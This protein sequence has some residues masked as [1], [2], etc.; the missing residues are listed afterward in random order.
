[1]EIYFLC[2]GD[3]EIPLFKT[4]RADFERNLSEHG[5]AGIMNE[6]YGLKEFIPGFDIIFT[7][8]ITR[9]MQTAD[10]FA[11]V[12]DCHDEVHKLIA[13]APPGDIEG[14]MEAFA[15]LGDVERILCVGHSP[16]LEIM[17]TEIITGLEEE[18]LFPLKNG[19][20]LC[21]RMEKPQLHSEAEIEYLMD[22]IFLIKLGEMRH[23]QNTNVKK[24]EL[25]FGQNA[26]SQRHSRYETDAD[27]EEPE[28]D[29]N[30]DENDSAG[31]KSKPGF[32]V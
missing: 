23:L 6:A 5:I 1:M 11:E 28:Y 21:F 25:K 10:I 8:P 3:A 32:F 4:P 13:L 17:A 19:G 12:F 2:H 30:E 14:L 29:D 26:K 20:I 15:F 22:P 18:R 16:S 27:D 24:S 7:S 31:E 9:A